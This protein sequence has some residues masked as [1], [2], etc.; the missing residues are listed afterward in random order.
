MSK[1]VEFKEWLLEIGEYYGKEITKT[2]GN[3]YWEALK[4]YNMKE[5]REAATRHIK[6]TERGPFFPKISDIVRM[7]EGTILD[8]AQA[9]WSKVD[10]AVRHV[11]VYKSVAFDD[12]I[13]HR[14]IADMGGW[15]MF[16]QKRDDEW[17]FVA[18]EFRQRY[19]GLK[20][21]GIDGQYPPYLPGNTELENGGNYDDAWHR[22]RGLPLPTPISIGDSAACRLVISGG[23]DKPL[24]HVE[25]IGDITR[26]LLL[27]APAMEAA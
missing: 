25:R 19:H 18:N 7:L 2:V 3:L 21:K 10:Y 24:H 15:P 1:L 9:A 17:P 6:N 13:I 27:P 22:E 8:H 12:P 14:V 20:A 11:G 26:A 4:G 16:G 23:S 5:L